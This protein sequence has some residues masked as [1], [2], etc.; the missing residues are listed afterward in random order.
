MMIAIIISNTLL[1]ERVLNVRVHLVLNF[2]LKK[3][4]VK[5]YRIQ[6]H[7]HHKYIAIFVKELLPYC[8]ISLYYQSQLDYCSLKDVCCC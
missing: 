6:S 5:L 2:Q 7:E 8:Y 1:L 4:K 3:I